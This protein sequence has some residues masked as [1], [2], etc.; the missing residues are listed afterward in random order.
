MLRAQEQPPR[1]GRGLGEGA[2]RGP[3]SPWLS[4]AEAL[5]PPSDVPVVPGEQNSRI[6]FIHTFGRYP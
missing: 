3:P 4:P 1:S 5:A 6:E 2:L